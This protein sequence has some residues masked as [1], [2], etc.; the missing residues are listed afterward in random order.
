MEQQP[1]YWDCGYDG[2]Y[3][4]IDEAATQVQIAGRWVH[5]AFTKDAETGVM[6]CS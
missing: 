5:W 3:D 6:K 2:G 4:R 1:G